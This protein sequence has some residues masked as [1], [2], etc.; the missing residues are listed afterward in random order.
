MLTRGNTIFLSLTL[1]LFPSLSLFF[2]HSLS[3]SLTL[4]LFPSLSLFFPHSLSF[5]LTLSLFPSLSLF[6]VLTLSLFPS[7]SLFFPHSLT[8]SPSFLLSFSHSPPS[9]KLFALGEGVPLCFY[10]ILALKMIS[11]LNKTCLGRFQDCGSG[12]SKYNVLHLVRVILY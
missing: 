1:S 10:F 7:H 2:P 8:L 3:F 11:I 4:S 12:N 9:C 6:F 5:S